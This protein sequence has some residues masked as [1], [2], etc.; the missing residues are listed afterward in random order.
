MTADMLYLKHMLQFEGESYAA[1]NATTLHLSKDTH[2]HARA[3]AEIRNAAIPLTLARQKV[4]HMSQV[5]P[6]MAPCVYACI[7][8]SDRRT[9][10]V[11]AALFCAE[12]YV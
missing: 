4:S 10:H 2:K 3:R 9:A 8:I 5:Q 11:F 6:Y 12:G 1:T 7:F